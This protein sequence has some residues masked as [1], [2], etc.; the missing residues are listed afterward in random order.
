[1]NLSIFHFGPVSIILRI[2]FENLNMVSQQH[3]AR[4]NYMDMQCQTVLALHW[5]QKQNTRD[6][7]RKSVNVTLQWPVNFFLFF[8]I[9]LKLSVLVGPLSAFQPFINFPLSLGYIRKLALGSL[10]GNYFTPGFCMQPTY[11]AQKNQTFTDTA[12]SEYQFMPRY[13]LRRLS[14]IKHI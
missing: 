5:Y 2:S 11:D 6:S 1:M 12:P 13:H 7:S 14:Y 9:M 10:W 4:A 8:F 3:R